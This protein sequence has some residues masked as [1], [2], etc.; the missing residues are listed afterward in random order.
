MTRNQMIILQWLGRFETVDVTKPCLKLIKQGKWK[1]VFLMLVKRGCQIH[2]I[3][4]LR[5][6]T[7]S[8]QQ[9]YCNQCVV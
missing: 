7:A 1:C 3:L 4:V 8:T 2:H 5:H 9:P 6:S